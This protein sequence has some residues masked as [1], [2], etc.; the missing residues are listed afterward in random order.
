MLLSNT[1]IPRTGF[2][3]RT[4]QGWGEAIS[5]PSRL[6]RHYPSQPRLCSHKRCAR[7]LTRRRPTWSLG[8][9]RSLAHVNSARSSTP[10]TSLTSHSPTLPRVL[11]RFA[12]V[13]SSATNHRHPRQRLTMTMTMSGQQHPHRAPTCVGPTRPT[14]SA[15][16]LARVAH[17]NCPTTTM[18]LTPFMSPE[19]DVPNIAVPI[20][21]AFNV[22]V[23]YPPSYYR[24]A[25]VE[26]PPTRSRGSSEPLPEESWHTGCSCTS[27]T[28]ITLPTASS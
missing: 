4:V 18:T 27:A 17:T 3:R 15:Q 7:S 13:R 11:Q 24:P 26:P 16:Y 6:L 21:P 28:I 9:T 23:S 20:A 10:C 22:H 12:S 2:S 25:Y 8:P 19:A 1:V 5:P 14:P